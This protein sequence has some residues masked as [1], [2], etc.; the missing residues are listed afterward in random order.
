[1]G[2]V[3]VYRGEWAE[4]LQHGF[5]VEQMHGG[6][7]RGQFTWGKKQGRGQYVW[8]DRSTYFGDWYA[9]SIRGYGYYVAQDG[10][11]FIGSWEDALI[12]GLGRY[13]WPDGRVFEGL[14]VRDRKEGFGVFHWKDGSR[15]EGWWSEGKQHGNGV[16]YRHDNSILRQG[17]WQRGLPLESSEKDPAKEL[18]VPNEEQ[19]TMDSSGGLSK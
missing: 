7:Y 14:Y 9:N 2:G 18:A 12:H 15:F 1:M 19:S 3:E 6:V 10:R 13:V 5:G 11:E 8:P 4:D 16:L 17:K